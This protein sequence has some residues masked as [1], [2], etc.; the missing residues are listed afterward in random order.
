MGGGLTDE[1]AVIWLKEMA[2]YLDLLYV[3]SAMGDGLM[4]AECDCCPG[5][6][7]SAKLKA[8]G[9]Q[10]PIAV[11]TPYMDLDKLEEVIASGKADVINSNH[12][13][14]CNPRL[15]EILKPGQVRIWS[16]ACSATSAGASAG[17][18]SG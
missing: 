14:M 8:A 10:T 1:E 2:P 4:E 7:Q 15:G 17:P 5:A 6:E 9:I 3:R 18:A 11:S 13:F 16:P 12:M